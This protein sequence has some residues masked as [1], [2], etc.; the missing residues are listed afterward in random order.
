MAIV[1]SVVARDQVQ[2]DGRRQIVE[3][4]TDHVGVVRRVEF[5]APADWDAEGYLATRAALIEAKLAEEE[6]AAN[7]LEV[8]GG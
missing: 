3:L 1:S 7:L 6:M 2:H 5:L 8:E 4:H